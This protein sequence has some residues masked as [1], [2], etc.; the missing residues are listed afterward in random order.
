MPALDDI[1]EHD[2]ISVEESAPLLEDGYRYKTVRRLKYRSR[3]DVSELTSNEYLPPV[4][5]VVQPVPEYIP[6]V[7]DV[8]EPVSEYITPVDPVGPLVD[9]TARLDV[10]GYKYKT[11]R[12]LKYRHRR[13]VSK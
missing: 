13:D 8:V 6:P 11:V 9:E 3:R 2:D 5:D 12:R 7:D 1:A 10:D 4:S